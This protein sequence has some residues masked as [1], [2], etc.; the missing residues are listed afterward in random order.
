M[1]EITGE[2][3]S[4]KLVEL[5]QVISEIRSLSGAVRGAAQKLEEIMK[6]MTDDVIS[7]ADRLG[8]SSSYWRE[9][10]WEP[11][12]FDLGKLKQDHARLRELI[13]KR[14]ELEGQLRITIK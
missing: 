4:K 1:T 7:N 13:K 9:P 2:E 14:N 8:G 3:R 5:D 12:Q 11:S 10:Q 6:F